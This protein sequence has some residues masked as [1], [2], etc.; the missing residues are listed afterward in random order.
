MENVDKK[1]IDL[2][3]YTPIAMAGTNV[4]RKKVLSHNS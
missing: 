3:N 4:L 1:W 2:C